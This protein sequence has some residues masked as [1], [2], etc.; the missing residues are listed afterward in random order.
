MCFNNN[1]NKRAEQMIEEI[2]EVK[3]TGQGYA[4]IMPETSGG[5]SSCVSQSSCTSSGSAF[6][7]LMGKKSEPQL[8]RV[9][10]PV[11]A[12]PGDKVVVGVRA[13][14][15]L[16]GSLLAYFLPL[17][18][19]LLSAVIGRFVFDF[20]GMNAELGS[21]LMG[22]VGLLAGFRFVTSLIKHTRLSDSFEAVILRVIEPDVHPVTFSLS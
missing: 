12:K 21:I 1:D 9:Q 4:E 20:L 11:C 18:I 16:K 17:L 19:L 22:V 2:A 14:T 10:N 5:C 8:I 13:N 3:R 15:V 6:S 7:F